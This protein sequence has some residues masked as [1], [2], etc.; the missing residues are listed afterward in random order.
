MLSRGDVRL[1]APEPEDLGCMFSLENETPDI[2]RYGDATGPYS[3]FSLRRY[4]EECSNDVF[5]DRQLRL[6][7]DNGDLT[8]GMIDL[9]DF[10]PLHSRAE[11]GIVM[12]V[13]HRRSGLAAV[14]LEIL[15]CH[16]FENLRIHQLVA[17]VDVDNVPSR[18]LFEKCGFRAVAELRD[19]MFTPG[20]GY[21]NIVIMQNISD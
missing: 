8:V 14:A 2:W 9:F 17:R 13:E 15:V 20:G 1:R 10:D 7:I 6:M 4:I 12:G 21:R 3:R 16:C 18:A 11:V 5:A 19:W